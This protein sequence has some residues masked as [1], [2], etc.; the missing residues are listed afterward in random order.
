MIMLPT[1]SKVLLVLLASCRIKSIRFGLAQ[2]V[3]C[4]LCLSF[5]AMTD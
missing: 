3:S 1:D 5:T 4:F 2:K